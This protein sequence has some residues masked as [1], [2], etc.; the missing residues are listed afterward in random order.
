MASNA[1]QVRSKMIDALLEKV[2]QDT[3]PSI[4][5]MDFIEEVLTPE[6]VPRYAEVLMSKVIDETYPSIT[7]LTRIRNLAGF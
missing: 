2:D 4:T 6:D 3:Y 7:M 1:D 5:M